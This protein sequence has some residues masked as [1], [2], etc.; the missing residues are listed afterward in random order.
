MVVFMDKGYSKDVW[1]VLFD[2]YIGELVKVSD[3]VLI[4][5]WLR[6]LFFN[7]VVGQ[8]YLCVFV[9]VFVYECYCSVFF[10]IFYDYI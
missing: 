4:G 7:V 3:N 10:C 9:V 5:N 2:Y 6:C 8:Y 1:I